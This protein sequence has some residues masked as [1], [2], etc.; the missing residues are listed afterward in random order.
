MLSLLCLRI[1]G[2]S[3]TL[4]DVGCALDLGFGQKYFAGTIVCSRSCH[5]CHACGRGRGAGWGGNL[6]AEDHSA[7]GNS[8]GHTIPTSGIDQVYVCAHDGLPLGWPVSRLHQPRRGVEDIDFF[9]RT[10]NPKPLLLNPKPQTY[11]MTPSVWLVFQAYG[12]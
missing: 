12:Q 8:S 11:T 4:R 7:T 5:G 2:F 1:S 9:F 6:P 10:R 3:N